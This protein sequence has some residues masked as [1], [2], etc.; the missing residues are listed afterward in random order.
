MKML[1]LISATVFFAAL[2]SIPTR[3]EEPQAVKLTPQI[4]AMLA[5]MLKATEAQLGEDAEP[6]DPETAPAGD[7]PKSR[8]A[9]KEPSA[10]LST[11]GLRTGSLMTSAPLG[12]RGLVGGAPRMTN[13]EWRQRFPLRK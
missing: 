13:E 9:L 12:G 7:A 1:S 3:A 6:A 8:S 2:F 4:Q 10:G 11:G 5:Q